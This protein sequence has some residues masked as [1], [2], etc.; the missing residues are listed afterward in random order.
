MI[1]LKRRKFRTNVIPSK[2]VIYIA[3]VYLCSAIEM[4]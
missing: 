4:C 3:D 1:N 2:R